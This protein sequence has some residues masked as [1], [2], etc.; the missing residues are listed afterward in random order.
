MLAWQSWN[1]TPVHFAGLRIDRLTATAT[2]LVGVVGWV[3][4]HFATRS[5]EGHAR[6]ADFLRVMGSALFAA[7]LVAAGTSLPLLAAGWILLGASVT[8]LVGFERPSPEA[9]RAARWHA[10]VSRVSDVCLVIALG[11]MAW[12]GR[13]LDLTGFLQAVPGMSAFELTPIALLVCVSAIARSA[14]VPFHLWL[15]ASAEAPTPVSALLHAGIVNA[16]GLLLIRTGPLIVR[17]PEAW[18]LLSVAGSLALVVGMLASWHQWRV[19]HAL[20]WSTVAQMG[21]MVIQCGVGA[22]AAALLHLLGH[23][24]YKALAFL[25]SGERRSAPREASRPWVAPCALIAGTAAAVA[26][27]PA[28]SKLTG[29]EPLH[30]PG[31]AALSAVVAMSVGQ[32]WMLLLGTA[33]AGARSIVAAA[34]VTPAWPLACFVLYRAAGLFL[35]PVIG[36]VPWPSGPAAWFAAVA[37]V[38]VIATLSLLHALRGVLEGAPFSRWLRV[39]AREGFHGGTL[40]DRFADAIRNPPKPDRRDLVHA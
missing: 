7:V 37:P 8:A 13:T 17:V 16:G 25:S 11:L 30:A 4:V 20:A 35:V 6:H 38:V 23:G 27:M 40:A 18:I 34:V 9:M 12:R 31:E 36:D 24:A 2:L 28:A 26:C 39:Q 14:L 29:F 22:F 10:L 1:P 15:P 5:M 19:K 21:F 33:G 3:T 32:A